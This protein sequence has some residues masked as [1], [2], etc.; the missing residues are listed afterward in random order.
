MVEVIGGK[1]FEELVSQNS[2][3]YCKSPKIDRVHTDD[4]VE[5]YKF[6][7]FTSYAVCPRISGVL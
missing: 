7:W 1:T 5:N 2:N 3:V 6:V 4:P